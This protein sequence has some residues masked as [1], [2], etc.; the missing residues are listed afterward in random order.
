MMPQPPLLR[1]ATDSWDEAE[2]AAI[3]RVVA[4]RQFSMGPEVAAFERDAAALFGSRHA[5]MVNSGSSANLVAIAGLVYHPNAPLQRGDEVIVPAVSWSTTFYPVHQLGLSLRFVDIDRDT[6]NIDL[7]LLEAALTPKTKGVL[8][9]NLLGNSVDLPRLRAFCEAHGLV[10]IE[11]NCESM[12]AEIGGKQAG[13]Y[14][15]CGTF[16]TFFSHHISTMEGGFVLTDDTVLYNTM[17]S[18]RAHGWVR[19]QPAD[20]HLPIPKD[21]FM[22]MFRFVLP[23]YNLR[24]LEMSGAI[25]QDQLRKLPTIVAARRANADHFRACCDGIPGIRIQVET[26]RSSWFGFAIVLQEHLQGRRAEL[27]TRLQAAGVECRPIVSGNF[28]ANPVVELLDHSVAGPVPVAEEI[29][30]NGLFI[31]NHHF[32]INDSLN[33]VGQLLREFATGQ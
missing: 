16:S 14:G 8:A 1:L 21:A 9:V 18:L 11:D 25:G 10:L 32:P 15:L 19:G 17:V 20:S 4:S 27:V 3:D 22:R 33:L 6:L 2:Y 31:G 30:A 26:G 7:N 5:L 29:D 12:G 23:G 24:P 13:T 28:L